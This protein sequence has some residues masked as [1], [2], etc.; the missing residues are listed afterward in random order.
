[1]DTI[2][3]SLNAA[4]RKARQKEA[5]PDWKDIRKSHF[6]KAYLACDGKT[7]ATARQLGISRQQVWRLK[8]QYGIA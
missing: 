2:D 8:V 3:I 6:L 4:I 7:V 1:M 5:L